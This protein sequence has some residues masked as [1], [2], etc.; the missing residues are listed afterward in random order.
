MDG[1]TTWTVASA[2]AR[3]SEVLLRAK[4]QPQL[5]TENGKAAAVV[6]S[7]EDWERRT[8]RTENLGEFLMRSPLKGVDLD[9][10]RIRDEP[11]DF[12]V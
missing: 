3:L 7:S 5:I 11:R 8:R 2:K 6:V 10:E 9:L 12:D 1:T 4:Q